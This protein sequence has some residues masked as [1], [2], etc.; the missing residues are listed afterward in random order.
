TVVLIDQEVKKLIQSAYDTA[1]NILVKHRKILEEMTQTLL[2]KE[3][4]TGQEIAQM[5]KQNTP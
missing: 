1:N 2:E 4:I 3:T 5:V